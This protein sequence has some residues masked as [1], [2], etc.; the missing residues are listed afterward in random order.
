[1]SEAP[2]EAVTGILHP[3]TMGVTVGAACSGTVLWASE[4]RSDATR[5]RAADAGLVDV[6]DLASMVATADMVISVCPPHGAEALADTVADTGFAGCYVDANAVSP[7]TAHK[8]GALFED[9]VDGS[10]IGPPATKPGTT[11]LYLS[12]SHAEGVAAR[13]EGS[14]LEPRV[15]QGGET[16]AASALKMAYASWTKGTSALLMSVA[17]LAAAEGVADELSAEWALSQSGLSQRLSY[18]AIAVGPKAWRWTGEMDEIADT[19]AAA[20]L[21]DGF[22]RAASEVFERLGVFKEARG[23]SVERMIAAL[24]GSAATSTDGDEQA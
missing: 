16:G 21:P 6:G 24:L 18:T 10:L 19:F 20:G 7:T 1:M 15:L 17:A 5:Q 9:F 13:F 11:R 22:H 4:G 3:G 23:A 14:A 8:I 2:Q 12:G